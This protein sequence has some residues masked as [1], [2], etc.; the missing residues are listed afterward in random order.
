MNEIAAHSHKHC[1]KNVI[2]I[3][4]F[5]EYVFFLFFSFTY[6]FSQKHLI[7][8]TSRAKK[9]RVYNSFFLLEGKGTSSSN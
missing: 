4:A 1:K 6:F 8:K 9:I 5:T 7:F 3:Q 2:N